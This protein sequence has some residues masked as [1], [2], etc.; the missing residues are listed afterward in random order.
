M[1]PQANRVTEGSRGKTGEAPPRVVV[2][3]PALLALYPV[4]GL[5]AHNAARTPHETVIRPALIAIA[6]AVLLWL[7]LWLLIRNRYRAGLIA[8]ILIF[9]T[10]SGW[11][12][13]Q[14]LLGRVDRLVA[15][16]PGPLWFIFY[17][18]LVGGAMAVLLKRGGLSRGKAVVLSLTIMAGAILLLGLVREVLAP[19]FGS[20]EGWAIAGYV[21]LVGAVL[22]YV[23]EIESGLLFITR[24]ANWFTVI[25]L[26]LTVANIWWNR[27]S[28]REIAPEPLGKTARHIPELLP[29]VFVFALDGY[30]RGDV[31]QSMYAYNNYPFLN[32]MRSKGFV[33]AEESYANYPSKILSMASCLNMSYLDTFFSGADNDSAG[34]LE[35]TNLYHNNRVFDFMKAQ[36]YELVALSS[37]NE[38]IEP[39]E[40]IDVQPRPLVGMREFEAVLIETTAFA[41][42]VQYGY[43]L[44]HGTVIPVLDMCER[45]RIETARTI[46]PALGREASDK[47]RFVFIHWTLPDVP[48]V[49]DEEG[50]YAGP[51][52]TLEDSAQGR[53]QIRRDDYATC[54]K[55]QLT[56][57]NRLIGDLADQLIA[58]VKRP[59]VI[60]VVS[61][62]GPGSEWKPSSADR[63]NTFER[64][65]NLMMARFPE[66]YAE[67]LGALNQRTTLVNAFRL[68]LNALFDTGLSYEPDRLV[69]ASEM[70]PF[71]AQEIPFPEA[72]P[73]ELDASTAPSEQTAAP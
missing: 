68:T 16:L 8:T 73:A 18:L 65:A 63:T 30:A 17:V 60:W 62:H 46:L 37:C 44:R 33:V 21:L 31:L 11:N 24:T 5:F 59:L 38:S 12:I 4:L 6:G 1:N 61:S 20:V 51:C 28:C 35:A 72:I 26:L 43:Y 22:V 13:L 32:A 3:H 45:Q 23:F 64:F 25:L 19:A 27:P 69:F 36:G 53:F 57:T 15:M 52:L 55:E 10:F 14:Y 50:G 9:S 42:M 34:L 49:F 70:G 56:F 7:A 41:P 54:Y 29:D 66:E 58:N 67:T 2:L 47:P 39:R 48:F 40:Q 71:G